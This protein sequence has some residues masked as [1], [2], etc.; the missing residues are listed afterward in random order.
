MK[1]N[2]ALGSG[3]V[4]V[5]DKVNMS[6]DISAVKQRV[7]DLYAG[8]G[9]FSIGRDRSSGARPSSCLVAPNSAKLGT[10]ARGPTVA[11]G[12]VRVRPVS[13]LFSPPRVADEPRRERRCGPT[14]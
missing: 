13:G 1:F 14:G 4:L 2:Q 9:G 11:L 10:G 8:A 7:L 3:N 6:L 12:P 5:G